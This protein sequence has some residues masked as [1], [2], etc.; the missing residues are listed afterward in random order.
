MLNSKPKNIKFRV[1]A[2]YTGEKTWTFLAMFVWRSDA[3]E[4]A[5][6]KFCAPNEV[7]I[8]HGKKKLEHYHAS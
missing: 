6:S 7:K 8:I 1:Y 4:Y 5:R 3:V 2:K